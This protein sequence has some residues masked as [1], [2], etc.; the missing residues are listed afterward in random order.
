[1]QN[2][3]ISEDQLRE[4]EKIINKIKE[5]SRDGDY[6]YRGESKEHCKVS[7][8]LYREHMKYY[9]HA[10]NHEYVKN[11][12]ES[13]QNP[14]YFI[15]VTL[16]DFDI[17]IAQREKLQAA[18][19]HIGEPPQD[20]YEDH[21]QS[22]T[23]LDPEPILTADEIEILTELQHYGDKTNLIDFT[24]DYL[25]AIYF[26]CAG[27]SKENGRVIV[28]EKTEEIENM[29]IRPYSPRHRV[30]AQK[31][32]FLYPPQG[33]VDVPD[34]N[35]V[36]IPEHLK[37]PMIMYLRKHHDL[38]AATIYNDLH[39]FITSEN[40]R[41]D[42]K[43]EFYLGLAFHISG[44]DTKSTT[45]SKEFYN[46]AIKHYNSAIKLDSEDSGSYYNRGECLLHLGQLDQAKIDIK[47]AKG[48]GLDV[49]SAFRNE[50]ENA[51]D[52]K[53]KTDIELP[54]DLAKMLGG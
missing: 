28:L 9:E 10:K 35:I 8:A 14:K 22:I 37:R 13:I 26:A 46:E 24:T 42:S 17:R 49:I 7:S 11:Y 15:Q 18:K 30:V 23:S 27:E 38:S 21:R 1:M 2:Q 36:T 50:Y 48:M 33:F 39:G 12:Y 31:S 25:I 47:T 5:K 44:L 4:I 16:K 53:E 32:I 51:E 40:K 43:R 41:Q 45:H 54:P 20:I 34:V 19:K 52:F 6:I 29:I 3:S